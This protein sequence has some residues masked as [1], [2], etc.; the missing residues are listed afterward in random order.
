MK[1]LLEETVETCLNSIRCDISYITR[2]NIP[3]GRGKNDKRGKDQST[4]DRSSEDRRRKSPSRVQKEEN[5]QRTD[6]EETTG[7]GCHPVGG[8]CDRRLGEDYIPLSYGDKYKNMAQPD[9]EYADA[10]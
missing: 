8:G 6:F 1:Q 2:E 7:G 4:L 5:I 9:S 3:N 10:I